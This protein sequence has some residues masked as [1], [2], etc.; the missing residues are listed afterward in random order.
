MVPNSI[1]GDKA[2]NVSTS[3]QQ[4]AAPDRLQPSL[5]PRSGFRRRVSLVVLL[6]RAAWSRAVKYEQMNYFKKYMS[7]GAVVFI[8]SGCQAQTV[9]VPVP[10]APTP[11]PPMSAEIVVA[12][13][14]FYESKYGK[15]TSQKVSGSVTETKFDCST[16]QPEDYAKWLSLALKHYPRTRLFKIRVSCSIPAATFEDIWV[17][18]RRLGLL[19]Y[20]Q[21]VL[22]RKPHKVTGYR[23]YKNVDD[24][25][26]H[27]LA[28][29]NRALGLINGYI[30]KGK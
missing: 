5:V 17:Y 16:N 3:T 10:T 15:S 14:K 6:P 7:I 2:C 18:D 27:V 19:K 1:V 26:I 23:V 25:A 22:S 29:D 11:R 30:A 20:F 24:A 9:Q 28:E 13:R 12:K 8:C 21:R 4:G